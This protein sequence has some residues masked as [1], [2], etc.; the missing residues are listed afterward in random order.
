MR[1]LPEVEDEIMATP[2]TVEQAREMGTLA[3]SKLFWENHPK[4]TAEQLAPYAGKWV[5]WWPDGTYIYDADE[6]LQALERRVRDAGYLVSFFNLTMIPRP[7]Q[8]E[9]PILALHMRFS[10]NRNNFPA[11]ELWKYGGK[12]VAWW[13]DGS[14]IVDFDD[15]GSALV[16]R[17]RRNGYD[18]AHLVLESIPFPGE[19]FV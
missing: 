19:S 6:S 4:F 5:V 16:D 2:V 11:E 9:D 8:E 12:T 17:L 7:D 14:R 3:L 13:L 15:D 10:E 1:C 18:F